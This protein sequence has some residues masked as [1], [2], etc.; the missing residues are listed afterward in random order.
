MTTPHPAAVA[1]AEKYAIALRK[2]VDLSRDE[3]AVDVA[4]HALTEPAALSA[5]SPVGETPDVSTVPS[6]AAIAAAEWIYPPVKVWTVEQLK[7]I[8][9]SAAVKIQHVI[10]SA[11]E[12]L[13]ERINCV[14]QDRDLSRLMHKEEKAA[15]EAEL[16][17]LR[18][19]VRAL[20]EDRKRLRYL[21]ELWD[22]TSSERDHIAK[23]IRVG[24]HNG[25]CD[26]ID[27][28]RAARP[29]TGGSPAPS[30]P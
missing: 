27:A 29:A 8:R 21:S 24:D 28:A 7:P 16:T 5:P 10:N 19:Q 11:I 22:P 20:E 18:E 30:S 3:W 13:V 12:P 9:E 4:R 23:W 17:A 15:M 14:K 6:D 2:I 26:A 25:M 1:A